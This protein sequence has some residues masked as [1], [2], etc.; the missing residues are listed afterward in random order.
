M[1]RERGEKYKNKKKKSCRATARFPP[2]IM[3]TCSVACHLCFIRIR[4]FTLS[5]PTAPALLFPTGAVI[6]FPT[7]TTCCLG[8]HRLD[9]NLSI[10]R[11]L[12]RSRREFYPLVKLKLKILLDDWNS[13]TDPTSLSFL[14][15]FVSPFSF[16]FFPASSVVR[17]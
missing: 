10:N 14:N 12:K 6:F 4:G 16:L 17:K 7:C 15:H 3:Q 11:E 2:Q 5:T 9:S 13:R 1:R 8:A